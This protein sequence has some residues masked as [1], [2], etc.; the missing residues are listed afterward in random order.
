MKKFT[1]LCGTWSLNVI[2]NGRLP[3]EEFAVKMGRIAPYVDYV[4]IREKKCTAKEIVA[5][6]RKLVSE[7]VPR[8]K[9]I[10]NDRVDV[11]VVEKTYGVQLAHHSLDIRA[12]KHSFP[13][14]KVGKSVHSAEEA[15]EAE[16]QGADYLLYGHIYETASKA[17]LPAKGLENLKCVTSSVTIP[18]IA[19]GGI[20]PEHVVPVIQAGASGIA[21]MSSVGEAA[22]PLSVIQSYREMEGSE[23]LSK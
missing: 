11:A 4:H 21:V 23:W 7:G 1:K 17:D 2:S 6:V 12:V 5:G 10:I 14:L 18:V 19:I 22:D 13:Q 3:L 8:S 16:K 20:K 9:I 15:Q